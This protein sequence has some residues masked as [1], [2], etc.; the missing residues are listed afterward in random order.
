MPALDWLVSDLEGQF[1][2]T[3]GMAVLGTERRFS[4]DVELVLFRIAQEALR[5]VWRHSGASRAW[6]TVEF[7][8]GK[9]TLAVTDNGKGFEVP[10]SMADLANI[11]KLGLAGMEERARLVDAELTLESEPGKGTT[12]T[13]EVPV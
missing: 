5:N 4:P 13:V 9:T 3:I 8:D 12:V 11:G 1:D 7:G 6:L 2:L 10:R